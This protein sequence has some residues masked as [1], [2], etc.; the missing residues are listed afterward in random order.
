MIE[1]NKLISR[2]EKILSDYQINLKDCKILDFG[3][4]SGDKVRSFRS[5]NYD[6]FGCDFK[7]KEGILDYQNSDNS[8]NNNHD[9]DFLKLIPQ[10]GDYELPYNDNSF[11]LIYSEQ[12]F[13]HVMN[14]SET[15]IEQSRILNDNGCAIHVF[16]SKFRIFEG[17]IKVPFSSILSHKIWLYFWAI[18]GFRIRE[19]KDLTIYELVQENFNF[20]NNR[21]NYMSKK[22]LKNHF[23]KAFNYVEF[24]EGPWIK[25]SRKLPKILNNKYILNIISRFYS[26]FRS[27]VVLMS[28]KEFKR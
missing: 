4:G 24:I 9:Q 23:Y 21:T 6:A 25:H 13:E 11:N 1:K 14:Y 2:Y 28:N 12:V 7:F 22:D 8:M 15:L 10:D 3:C 16:P 18:I 19:Q 5:L 26:T 27:R 17:H 20:L